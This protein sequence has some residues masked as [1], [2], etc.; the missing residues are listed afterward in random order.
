M[1]PLKSGKG[2]RRLVWKVL[3]FCCLGFLTDAAQGTN[4]VIS[5]MCNLKSQE[6]PVFTIG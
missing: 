2:P 6:L 3:K 5:E 1:G 4:S